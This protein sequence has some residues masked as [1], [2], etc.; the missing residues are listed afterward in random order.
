[1]RSREA[2]MAALRARHAVAAGDA[3]EEVPLPERRVP[4]LQDLLDHFYEFGGDGESVA[5]HIAAPTLAAP[6]LRRYGT[7]PGGADAD[8]RRLYHAMSEDVL[9]LV[10]GEEA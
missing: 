1:G 2:I 5:P 8:L 3:G 10:F 9:A 6:L 4:A 7:A